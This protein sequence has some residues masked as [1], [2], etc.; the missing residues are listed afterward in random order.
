[1]KASIVGASGYGGGELLRL[2]MLHPQVEVH[3]CTSERF[4]GKPVTR[5]HPNLR[6]RT[7]L[8]FCSVQD[9]EKTDLLFTALP[10]TRCMQKFE[11]FSSVA[12]RIIDLSADFR[13]KDAEAY[14]KWYGIDH[15]LP[16]RLSEFVYGNL[17]LHRQERKQTRYIS[18]AGFNA[19][20]FQREGSGYLQAGSR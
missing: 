6:K 12:D 5:L 3:Q 9:L 10:H 4:V 8:K 18:V 1:M 20:S 17:E 11:E 15:A 16:A 7:P 13:L 14:R 19:T 2:L